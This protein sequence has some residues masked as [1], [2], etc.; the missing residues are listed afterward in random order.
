VGGLARRAAFIGN[1]YVGAGNSQLLVLDGG[2]TLWGDWPSDATKQSQGRVM[3]EAMNRMGC[4]AM[5]LGETDLQ[6][7]VGILRQRIAEARFPV[8]AANVIVQSTGDWLAAPYAL[9]EVGGRKVGIIGLA[10][11]ATSE[12]IGAVAVVDAAAAAAKYVTE[13]Q[14]QTDVIL[15]LSGLG[16]EANV[17]L[18]EAVP[19]IDVIIGAADSDVSTE[20]WQSAR[21]HTLVCQLSMAARRKP[22]WA[23]ILL[24]AVVD[25]A[26][27]VIEY[28]EDT[29]QLDRQWPEDAEMQQFL[30]SYQDH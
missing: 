2:N 4:Q 13:L 14:S 30:D 9:L 26:G 16:W 21:T 3:I 11:S 8:L 23:V 19:G 7:G 10:G 20:R 6:L 12:A 29:V 18:A 17:G 28:R 25:C 15:V 1:V 24:R 27:V 22:E 5:A